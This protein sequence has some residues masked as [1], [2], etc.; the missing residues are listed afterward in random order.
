[1]GYWTQSRVGGHHWR[2]VWVSDAEE[3]MKKENAKNLEEFIVA[4]YEKYRKDELT[5]PPGPCR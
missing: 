1:M 2:R 4:L 5:S 3:A